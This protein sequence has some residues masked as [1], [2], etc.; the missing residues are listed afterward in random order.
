MTATPRW[1][2]LVLTLGAALR[3]PKDEEFTEALNEL[4]EQ[5]WEVINAMPIEGSNKVRV[6]ARRPQISESRRR[7]SWPE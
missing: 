2:Y 1:E 5:G 7:R 4:G 3:G 6:L